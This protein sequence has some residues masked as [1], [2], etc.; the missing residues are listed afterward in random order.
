MSITGMKCPH[1]AEVR[2][3]SDRLRRHVN[4]FHGRAFWKDCP[5]EEELT[6]EERLDMSQRLADTSKRLDEV[7]AEIRELRTKADAAIAQFT[8]LDA[9]M[10]RPE[11]VR[12]TTLN[13]VLSKLVDHGCLTATEIIRHMMDEP[14][15]TSGL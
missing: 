15:E 4:Y 5:A 8:T 1:C 7:G 6:L 14:S 13:Q 12:R 2:P 11:V 9:Y 3:T 10:M